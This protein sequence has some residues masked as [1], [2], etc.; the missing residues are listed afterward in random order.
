MMGK[1]EGVT[2]KFVPIA[3]PLPPFPQNLVKGT[4]EGKCSRFKSMLKQLSII[5]P[6]IEALK[7][8]PGY[9]KF[10]M[11]MVKKNGSDF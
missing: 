5:I 2:Q 7:K 10:M 8:M 6:L 9:V 3:R 11:D 1:E 4:E